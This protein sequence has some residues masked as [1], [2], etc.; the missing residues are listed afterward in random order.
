MHFFLSI[1]PFFGEDPSSL[2]V[3]GVG[4]PLFLNWA[5]GMA[6]DSGPAKLYSTPLAT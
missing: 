3:A 1:I 2:R 4:L 5:L 6:G